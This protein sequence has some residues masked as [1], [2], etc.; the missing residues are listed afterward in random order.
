MKYAMFLFPAIA[1]FAADPP[2]IPHDLAIQSLLADKAL[3]EAQKALAEAQTQFAL[4]C[5][6]KCRQALTDVQVA[7]QKLRDPEQQAKALDSKA[8]ALCGKNAKL[9]KDPEKGPVCAAIPASTEEP[10]S[11]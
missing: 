9:V 7:A 8:Q 5:D 3:A 10:K 11:R 4:L 6:P 2:V 1:A